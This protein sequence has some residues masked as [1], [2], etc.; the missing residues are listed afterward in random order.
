MKK[1]LI[2]LLAAI[3]M[4]S[5]DDF[6]NTENLTKKDTGNY[7]ENMTEMQALLTGVYAS[8]RLMEIDVEAKSS[9]LISQILS[10]DC[11][12]GGGPD[13]AL[14]I[15][16]KMNTNDPEFFITTWTNAYESLFRA[17]SLLN[18]T[19]KF[20]GWSNNNER[21]Y[22]EG[23]THFLRGYTLYYL[24][25]MFGTAPMPLTTEPLNLPRASA[26]EMFGQIGAD[27]KT[28]IT[29]LPSTPRAAERGRATKWAAQALM[30]RA[31]LFYTGYYNKESIALPDGGTITKANVIA[32]LQDCETNSGHNLYTAGNDINAG[33]GF[34]NLWPYSNTFTKEDG[35]GFSQ[36]LDL[37]WAGETGNNI[38]T[39]F[40]WQNR[41]QSG[42]GNGLESY[43]NRLVHYM[44]PRNYELPLTY[45][46]GTGWGFA[47]V[48]PQLWK[49]WGATEPN[50]PRRKG[51]IAD[52]SDPDEM[53]AYPWGADKQQH[54]SGYLQK[55][56]IA[57]NSKNGDVI[58]NYAREMY[59]PTV[60]TDY[61]INNTQDFVVIRFA[62]VLLMLAELTQDAAP[63]NQVRSRAGLD[64]VAYS[65]KNLQNERRWEFAFE[66]LRYYDLL[67]W[68]IAAE[69]I[70]AKNGVALKFDSKD[71]VADL[72]DIAKRITDTGG[73]MPIPV[74]QVQ[75]SNGVLVQTPGW[76]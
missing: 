53:S 46:Y 63:L 15:A 12:M 41:A 19:E 72:G 61:Q 73:F 64:G 47:P 55:K 67:R 28:A 57:I 66:G 51:S 16:N 6:L 44:S 39:V 30:A 50:D 36:K 26:D 70:G 17:N 1:I 37:N 42:W 38:E 22:I 76:K 2:F 48:N 4:Y 75:L 20:T 49:E 52:V 11:F 7:P 68:H 18:S 56:Y 27:L 23:Q 25:K 34:C 31:F 40:A 62:D 54:E 58:E 45:P 33:N 65:D 29:M 35:Y 3:A 43:P 9:Y 71:G 24:A 14:H 5:C 60:Q 32:W 8:A 13:D 59:G 21:G 74:S 10:D 69:K